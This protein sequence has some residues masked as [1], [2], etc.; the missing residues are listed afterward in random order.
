MHLAEVR[1]LDDV[2]L[3]RYLLGGDGPAAR[4]EKVAR[5]RAA[6][7]VAA[8]RGYGGMAGTG[9][10]SPAAP[11]DGA[12]AT[13][14]DQAWLAQTIDLSRRCPPS[15]AAFC[16]G[17]VVVAADGTV[18]ATGYSRE[19]SPQAHAEETALAKIGPGGSRLAGATLYSSLEPCRVRAS[20]PTP[21]A[22]LIINAGLRRVVIAWLEPPVF[23]RGGGAALLREAGITVVEVP[24]LAAEARAVNAAVLSE[25]GP[26]L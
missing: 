18:M 25:H 24:G 23:A 22:E 3:L 11:G 17:A 21:C 6:R 16:V 12:E 8:G 10:L 2:V 19:T 5:E 9:L 20:R 26:A 13:A 1:Q 7:D 4:N 14:A 15:P